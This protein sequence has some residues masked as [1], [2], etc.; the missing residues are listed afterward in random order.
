MSLVFQQT[1]TIDPEP[2]IATKRFDF[3]VSLFEALRQLWGAFGMA[4][5]QC[6]ASGITSTARK[7]MV[8]HLVS[9]IIQ[10]AHVRSD[11]TGGGWF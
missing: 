8:I 6:I 4:C 10:T 1:T 9:D 2:N 3:Q 7:T 11:H 5:S